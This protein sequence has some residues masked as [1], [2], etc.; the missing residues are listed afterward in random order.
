M[1]ADDDLTTKPCTICGGVMIEWISK[2]WKQHEQR[3]GWTCAANK[4]NPNGLGCG[5]WDAATGR[6]RIIRSKQTQAR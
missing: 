5:R 3:T 4:H 2:T 6:E 1:G